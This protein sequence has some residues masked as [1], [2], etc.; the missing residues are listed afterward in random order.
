MGSSGRA[1]G[2]ELPGRAPRFGLR[3]LGVRATLDRNGD[4]VID[5]GNSFAVVDT[6]GDGVIDAL[7]SPDPVDVNGDGAI[8][9]DDGFAFL[10]V[11]GDGASTSA[12]A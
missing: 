11:N 4:G 1:P 7:D 3:P 12:T 2:S 8:D 9:S 10:D 6:N 5:A